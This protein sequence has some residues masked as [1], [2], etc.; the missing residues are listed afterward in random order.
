MYIRNIYRMSLSN[1]HV[2]IMNVPAGECKNHRSTE[3]RNI[4]TFIKI[5]SGS[6]SLKDY[7]H[8][9]RNLVGVNH[10]KKTLSYN[11]YKN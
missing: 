3:S 6:V 4:N 7:I 9:R 1:V 5:V 2:C 10:L 8:D 11:I